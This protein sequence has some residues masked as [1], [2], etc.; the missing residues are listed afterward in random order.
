MPPRSAF[1]PALRGRSVLNFGQSFVLT[2]LVFGGPKFSSG[3]STRE[4]GSSLSAALYI[5]VS[6]VVLIF[7]CLR[8]FIT[9]V[10]SVPL[11]V[12]HRVLGFSFFFFLVLVLTRAEGVWLL[13]LKNLRV[14]RK[15][16]V[17]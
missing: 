2:V 8:S 10:N 9:F 4:A 13:P 11:S 5:C 16:F 12:H 7:L 17:F 6:P 1:S 14:S 3:Q 15:T